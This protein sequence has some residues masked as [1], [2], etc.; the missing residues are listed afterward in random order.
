FKFSYLSI[1]LLIATALVA[2]FLI[3]VWLTNSR[4]GRVLT[5]IRDNETRVLAL[6][7]STAMYKT[8]VF[9]AAGLMAGIAGALY[10]ASERT[11]GARDSFGIAF[12]IEIVILVAVGGRGTLFGPV[13][14]TVLVLLGKTYANNE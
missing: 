5:A 1:F 9:A 3:C 12:S 13:I 10:V 6:G 11:V 4:F 14:G 2:G 8:F 7:Y